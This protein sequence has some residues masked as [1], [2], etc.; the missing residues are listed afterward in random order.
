[1]AKISA[2]GEQV[3]VISIRR[4][5]ERNAGLAIID[6]VVDDYRLSKS[7]REEIAPAN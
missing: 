2:P 3:T 7:L 4:L 5:K 6:T 1:M